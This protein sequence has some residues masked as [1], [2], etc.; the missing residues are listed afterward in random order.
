MTGTKF[1]PGVF[2][3]VDDLNG[4][5]KVVLVGRDGVTYWDSIH[6]EQVTPLSIHPVMK[7][8]A[9]GT[10][11][12]FA[13]DKKLAPAIGAVL[14]LLRTRQTG[15]DK[16]SLFVMRV[17][18]I[19]SASATAEPMPSGA[20]LEHACQQAEEQEA[21]ALRLLEHA[22]RYYQGRTRVP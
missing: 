22:Q 1:Q 17:L 16:D 20:A 19:L 10:V 12:S 8:I 4:G 7:P 5:R 15:R 2:L 3:E 9:L 14:D 6:V 21:L 11:V 18:W 13:Q